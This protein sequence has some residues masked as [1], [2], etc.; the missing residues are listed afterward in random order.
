VHPE[1]AEA[2]RV[3]V[4]RELLNELV[5]ELIDAATDLGMGQANPM[6]DTDP[7]EYNLNLAAEKVYNA[8][9]AITED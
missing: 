5:E 6:V 7:L 9:H 2:L 3:L 8:I 4:S 1:K